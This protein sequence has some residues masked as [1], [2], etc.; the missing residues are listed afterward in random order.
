MQN[1]EAIIWDAIRR[2]DLRVFEQYY[3]QEHHRFFVLACQ[4]VQ[5][6]AAALAIVNDIF[7]LLWTRSAEIDIQTTLR[8]YIYRSVINRCINHL[9]KEKRTAPV[10]V[11]QLPDSV[12]TTESRPMEDLELQLLLLRAIEQLPDQCRK[13]FRMS[14]F[15]KLKQQDIADKLGISIATVKTHITVALK[16]LHRVLQEWSTV[17]IWLATTFFFTPA[18]TSRFFHCLITK[19]HGVLF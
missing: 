7:L 18:T 17:W 10:L 6:P 4:Y 15:E 19:C 1:E 12:A 5:D 14:R 3:K 11:Q 8:G 2:K 9:E 13:V 16:R